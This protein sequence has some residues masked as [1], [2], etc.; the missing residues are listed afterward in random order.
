[1]LFRM[2]SSVTADKLELCDI[3]DVS[4]A[5]ASRERATSRLGR[6]IANSLLRHPDHWHM[7]N[8]FPEYAA[9][10]QEMK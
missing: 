1:M 10:R 3:L 9:P 5:E 4:R 2:S 8:R 7:W 6:F